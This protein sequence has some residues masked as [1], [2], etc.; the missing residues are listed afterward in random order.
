MGAMVGACCTESSAAAAASAGTSSE[1]GG[2]SS[3]ASASA[4]ASELAAAVPTRAGISSAPALGGGGAAG[5]VVR[6]VDGRVVAGWVVA[7][8]VAA[9]VG[10]AEPSDSPSASWLHASLE[11]SPVPCGGLGEAAEVAPTPAAWRSCTGEEADAAVEICGTARLLLLP[12]DALLRTAPC[13]AT[14]ASQPSSR[15]VQA[16]SPALISAHAP[17]QV[18]TEVATPSRDAGLVAAAS[19]SGRQGCGD[20]DGETEGDAAAGAAVG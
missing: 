1:G 10:A 3:A 2:S 18:P 8:R 9:P 20:P 11:P 19:V 6:M 15:T 13:R 17:A 5:R 14:A 12:P 16:P 7:G 4:S